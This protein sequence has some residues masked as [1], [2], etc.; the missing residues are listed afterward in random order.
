MKLLHFFLLT[1]LLFIQIYNID[2]INKLQIFDHY[3]NYNKNLI[4]IKMKWVI[5][6]IK[7]NNLV[8]KNSIIYKLKHLTL[9]S[10]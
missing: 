1:F 8:T 7:T 10:Q 6:D 9:N 3:N 4:K 2:N 5:I